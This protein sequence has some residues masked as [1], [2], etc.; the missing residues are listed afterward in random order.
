M[1][2]AFT[3]LLLFRQQEVGANENTWGD[4]LNEL[5]QQIEDA[6]AGYTALTGLTGGSYSLSDTEAR[7]AMI[8]AA[9][10]LVADQ[11]LVLPNRAKMWS[12]RNLTTGAF[13][14]YV[15][16]SGGGPW[17]EI[18]KDANTGGP[19]WI[20][21]YGGGGVAFIQEGGKSDIVEIGDYI[22]S[23]SATKAK[24]LKVDGTLYATASYPDLF[25]KIGYA[26]GGSGANFAVPNVVDRYLRGASGSNP[27]GTVLGSLV[28]NH[29]HNFTT[30]F[31]GLHHHTVTVFDPGHLHWNI[32][33]CYEA[34]YGQGGGTITTGH[35]GGGST[36]AAVTGITATAL[37]AG[38]GHQ[39][40][41]VT[42]NN[43]SGGSENRP[44][45]LCGNLFIRATL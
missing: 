11:Y 24:C 29:T 25:A 43:N 23:N 1:A 44:P 21:T 37:S 4:K 13:K 9:G 5:I 16:V 28:L 12:M 6:I 22:W 27:V 26:H 41:G 8:S 30:N 17:L 32:Y 31:D 42:N 39:H 40:S 20:Y 2:D 45:S 3:P 34:A 36:D 10:T 15:G 18:L 35:Q 38:S 14:L 7:R 33:A 19:V